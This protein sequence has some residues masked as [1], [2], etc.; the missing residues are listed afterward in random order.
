MCDHVESGR[1]CVRQQGIE[2]FARIEDRGHRVAQQGLAAVLTGVPQGQAPGV[3]LLLHPE[4]KRIIK[5]SR[6]PE[7]KLA[8]L[9]QD[10]PVEDQQKAQEAA[11][12]K[13]GKG[14]AAHAPTFD[15]KT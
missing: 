15:S 14:G 8:I 9:E 13:E 11:Q 7:A 10:R 4:V 5:E 1:P 3:P 6:I 12:T 2:D